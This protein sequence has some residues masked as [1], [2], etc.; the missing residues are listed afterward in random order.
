MGSRMM[1][2]AI[3]YEV[4]K[5]I[6]IENLSMF[7]IGA[8]APDATDDKKLT[9]YFS[10]DMKTFD[11]AV[12]YEDFVNQNYP[13]T[14][15]FLKGYYTHLV[16]DDIWINGFYSM[17]LKDAMDS[18]SNFQK[19]YYLD[20]QRLNQIILNEY[21]QLKVVLEE[22]TLDDQSDSLNIPITSIE[23]IISDIQA[24]VSE[25]YSSDNLYLF[26][27]A[28]ILGYIKS[29]AKKSAYLINQINKI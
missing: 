8:L 7:L 12:N 19:L 26:S 15:D 13:L 29:S 1:H 23:M 5:L 11:R 18:D 2:V 16:A 24:D 17:W 25:L 4:S 21:P 10:G 27:K 6:E 14:N 20:F 9:H 3:A 22:L 28:Q